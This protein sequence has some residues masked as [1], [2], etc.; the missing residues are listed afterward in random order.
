MNGL[1]REVAARHPG[2]VGLVDLAS[3]VCPSGPPCPY[4][5]DGVGAGQPAA[6][7]VRPDDYH[8]EVAGSLWVAQWLI[9]QILA[10]VNGR[11]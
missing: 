1:L 2:R 3:R 4:V 11:S 10:F 6:D 8:Y 5:V 9:P 7:S